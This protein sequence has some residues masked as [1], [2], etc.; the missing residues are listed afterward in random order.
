V[1]VKRRSQAPD[2]TVL[3]L[4]AD[5]DV[6]E[7]RPTPTRLRSPVVVL[8]AIGALALAIVAGAAIVVA[9]QV[10]E[11]TNL[12]RQQRCVQDAEAL[13]NFG[14]SQ[15]AYEVALS[16]CFPNPAAVRANEPLIVVPGAVGETLLQ[17]E[18]DLKRVGLR[19]LPIGGPSAPGSLVIK[20][21]PAAGASVPPGTA[22]EMTTQAF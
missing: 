2:L 13:S 5:G 6:V 12:L 20:Q 11:E 10:S 16:R 4:D 9:V 14:Q 8:A 1:G 19:S 22:V 15:G 17:A 18:S 7:A 21:Q 3:P